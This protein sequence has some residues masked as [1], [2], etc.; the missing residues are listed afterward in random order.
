M[1]ADSNDDT[2]NAVNLSY[3]IVCSYII[4]HICT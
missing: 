2:Y 1:D 3:I 4:Q